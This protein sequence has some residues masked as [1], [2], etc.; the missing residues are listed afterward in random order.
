[1]HD[2]G[3]LLG[4]L[5]E[6]LLGLELLRSRDDAVQFLDPVCVLLGVAELLLDVLLE[7][8]ADLLRPHAIRVDRVRDIAHHGLDLHPVRLLQQLQDLC[9][10]LGVLR[11]EDAESCRGCHISAPSLGSTVTLPAAARP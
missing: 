10:L 6:R 11:G 1:V 2:V 7:R 9:P 8:L 5:Q 3:L 4:R